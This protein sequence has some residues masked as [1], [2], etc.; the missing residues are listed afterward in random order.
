MTR[1]LLI[2]TILREGPCSQGA[3]WVVC[4]S[5]VPLYDFL[6]L[7]GISNQLR[8]VSPADDAQ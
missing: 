1:I 5:G 8:L 3:S 4:S 6:N 2:A 7:Y